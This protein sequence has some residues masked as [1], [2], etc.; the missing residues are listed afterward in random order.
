MPIAE[1]PRLQL[2]HLVIEDAAFFCRQ[3]N[4]P[5][6]L[7]QIGDRGVRSA[8]DAANY[9]RTKT[10]AGYRE[11]G[12]GM[13]LLVR[14]EDA[15]PVGVCGLVKRDALPVPD[16]GF[17]LLETHW[18]QGYA[19]EAARAVLRHAF[20]DLHL[21]RLLAITTQGNLPSQKLLQKLGFAPQGLIDINQETLRLFALEAVH[22]S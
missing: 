14:R 4:E 19:E 16:I 17:A 1:T 6:W 10:F 9:L 2:R 15:V 13:Y 7:A 11:Q 8:D 21:S 12:F 3:L 18:G 22:G 5:T 20:D